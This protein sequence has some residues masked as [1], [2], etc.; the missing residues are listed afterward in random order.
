LL[1]GPDLS[2]VAERP[3]ETVLEDILDP[4][5]R[6][7]PDFLGYHVETAAGDSLSGL[8]V[9]ETEAS[10]TLRRPGE[11]D[12]TLLRKELKT[13]RASGQS[14]M[15]DGLEQGIVPQEM[16]DLLGFLARPDWTWVPD[17]PP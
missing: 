14:I 12:R 13:I 16:A 1:I 11:P 8:I 17:S 7:A 4:S 2:S 10:L 3:R 5:A 15:P 9:A 6:I